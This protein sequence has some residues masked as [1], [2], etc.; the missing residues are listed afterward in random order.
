MSSFK[1]DYLNLVNLLL[2]KIRVVTNPRPNP[3]TGLSLQERFSTRL[4][5]VPY[6]N[7]ASH[8]IIRFCF[9]IGYVLILNF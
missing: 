9:L 2:S 5:W 3:R 8:K 1:V 6:S 4:V 7:N